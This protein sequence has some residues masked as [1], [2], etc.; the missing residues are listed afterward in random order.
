[1]AQPKQ[2]R[3][4][5]QA[6]AETLAEVFRPH[7]RSPVW[8]RYAE[9]LDSQVMPAPLIANSKWLLDLQGIQHNLAFSQALMA[10]AFT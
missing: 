1:M 9:R 10:K 4:R 7:V 8:F 2:S 3:P 5:S 6:D